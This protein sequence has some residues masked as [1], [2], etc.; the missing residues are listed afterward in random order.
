[1]SNDTHASAAQAVAALIKV[2]PE[3]TQLGER[4]RGAGHRLALVGGPVRD[5]LLGQ[6]KNSGG[7]LDFTTDALPEVTKELLSGW[8]DAVWSTGIEYGTIAAQKNGLSLEIT[9]YRSESYDK[10]SRKPDVQ[11][12]DSLEGD[13]SRRDFTVNAMALELD[14]K[15]N[16]FI[17]PHNGMQDLIAKQLRTPGT[18]EQSFSDDPLRMMRAARFAKRHI[19]HALALRWNA[20]QHSK[21][22]FL[23]HPGFKSSGKAFV[24]LW[25]AGQQQAARGV[26]IQP[27]DGQRPALKAEGQA[28]QMIFDAERFVARFIDRKTR[29]FVEDKC[30]AI[31]EKNTVTQKHDGRLATPARL[32]PP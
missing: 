5:A 21:I 23:N 26:A 29:W 17:D 15:D 27:V 8:A 19:D 31:E 30:L 32:R 20:L 7:D 16:L 28:A 11:Y 4:F 10:D 24:R 22:G 9:T 1:M 13:L 18:P 2:P 6:Q 12:G 25:I 3:A 14:G